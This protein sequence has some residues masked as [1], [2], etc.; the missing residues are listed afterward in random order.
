MD[1]LNSGI[2]TII[3]ACC[4]FAGIKALIDWLGTKAE[5]ERK[6]LILLFSLLFA[7]NLALLWFLTR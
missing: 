2:F 7:A 5:G 3:A 6:H 4:L 1:F